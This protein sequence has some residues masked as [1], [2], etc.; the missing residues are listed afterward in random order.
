MEVTQTL[1]VRLGLAVRINNQQSY[2]VCMTTNSSI[3]ATINDSQEFMGV[4]VNRNCT[5]MVKMGY[6]KFLMGMGKVQTLQM[7]QLH[8]DDVT[9]VNRQ[10][11]DNGQRIE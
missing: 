3:C 10:W 11:S 5:Y 6:Q 2:P 8:N 1:R 4:F 7:N 9:N